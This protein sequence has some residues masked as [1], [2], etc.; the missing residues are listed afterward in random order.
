M[1]IFSIRL[2]EEREYCG[3]TQKKMAELLDITLRTYQN[4]EALGLNNR[5]PDY[6]MLVKIATLLDVSTDYLLGKE[7]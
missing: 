5:Q 7:D 4:Y 1:K 2:K 6:E 3:Y